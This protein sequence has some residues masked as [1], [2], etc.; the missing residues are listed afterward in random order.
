LPSFGI[1]ST[2]NAITPFLHFVSTNSSESDYSIKLFM[3]VL[4]KIM[5]IFLLFQ[6]ITFSTAHSID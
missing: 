2:D 5:L 1:I 6:S 4:I 3:P